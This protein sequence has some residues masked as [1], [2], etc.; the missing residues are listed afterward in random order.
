MHNMAAATAIVRNI[1]TSLCKKS[2][3]RN[4]FFSSFCQII[5]YITR[6]L[7]QFQNSTFLCLFFFPIDVFELFV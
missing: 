6:S 7:L 4:L 5:L 3:F 1:H 2:R